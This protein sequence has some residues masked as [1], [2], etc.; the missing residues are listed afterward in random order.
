MAVVQGNSVLALLWVT[1]VFSLNRKSGNFSCRH[2][3]QKFSHERGLPQAEDGAS[4][5]RNYFA[6]TNLETGGNFFWEDEGS[7]LKLHHTRIRDY[8]THRDTYAFGAP[9]SWIPFD[10]LLAYFWILHCHFHLISDFG[11]KD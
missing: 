2:T 4:G 5:S 3:S 8:S 10:Q 1:P 9:R 11:F 6:I 7:F